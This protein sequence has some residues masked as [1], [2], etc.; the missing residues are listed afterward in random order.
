MPGRD[1]FAPERPIP[2]RGSLLPG[3][4]PEVGSARNPLPATARGTVCTGQCPRRQTRRPC[5]RLRPNSHPREARQ[6]VPDPP[7][8]RPSLLLIPAAS[9]PTTSSTP[10][11]RCLVSSISNSVIT[12]I[13][14]GRTNAAGVAVR[15]TSKRSRT[16]CRV[17]RRKHQDLRLHPALPLLP[18]RRLVVGPHPRLKNAHNGLAS[19]RQEGCVPR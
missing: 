6:L 18:D 7:E 3:F 19:A 1:G 13:A 10:L 5:P 8:R 16:P 11:D 9:W 12:A 14:H 2:A 4:S 17:R 15:H